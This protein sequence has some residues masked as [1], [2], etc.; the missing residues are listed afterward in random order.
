MPAPSCW[1]RCCRRRRC[2]ACRRPR[3]RARHRFRTRPR[4]LRFFRTRC[5]RDGRVRPAADGII[6]RPPAL[7]RNLQA[8]RVPA[9]VA[10]CPHF[11][12][13]FLSRWQGPPVAGCCSGPLRPVPAWRRRRRPQRPVTAGR[14]AADWSMAPHGS[15]VSTAGRRRKRRQPHL[16]RARPQARPQGP[17]PPHLC[18]RPRHL[19]PRLPRRQAQA[20]ATARFPTSAMHKWT[21]TGPVPIHAVR[22]SRGSGNSN[23]LQTAAHS[24]CVV[25]GR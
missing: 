12:K 19:L 18:R 2:I 3:G 22:H 24:A 16:R 1:H 20:R 14:R 8:P 23:P 25:T 9:S 10:P 21:T 11:P 6:G 5:Y 7:S 15:H 17:L 13:P 4:G